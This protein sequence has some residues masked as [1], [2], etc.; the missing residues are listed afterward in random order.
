MEKSGR[1]DLI[2]DSRYSRK[3]YFGWITS[4]ESR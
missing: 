4:A 3:P 2:V 1:R